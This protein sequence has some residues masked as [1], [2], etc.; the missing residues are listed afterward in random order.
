MWLHHGEKSSRICL[1]T[2]TQTGVWRTDRL[3]DRRTSCQGIGRAY[4]TAIGAVIGPIG[5]NSIF[6]Q[7]INRNFICNM[8]CLNLRCLILHVYFIHTITHTHVLRGQ[9]RK[10]SQCHLSSAVINNTASILCILSSSVCSAR[11]YDGTYLK[12]MKSWRQTLIFSPYTVLSCCWHG[13]CPHCAPVTWKH[14]VFVET[15]QSKTTRSARVG[16]TKSWLRL[17]RLYYIRYSYKWGRA[18]ITWTRLSSHGANAWWRCSYVCLSVCRFV[19]RP[20]NMLSHMCRAAP[21][22]GGGFSYRLRY[23]LVSNSFDQIAI[24][25]FIQFVNY[26]EIHWQ[27]TIVSCLIMPPTVGKG[28]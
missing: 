17:R 6:W 26:S 22:A 2:S 18:D 9:S 25:W 8:E 20:W 5:R 14:V 28:Q 3:T 21:A 10:R 12:N 15:A 16:K 11:S 24:W 19:C 7:K 4:G 13:V 1:L 23:T 27:K